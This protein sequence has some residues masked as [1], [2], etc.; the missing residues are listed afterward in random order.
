[1]SPTLPGPVSSDVLSV[2]C[3]LA[4]SRTEV[5]SRIQ[6]ACG[7]AH[8]GLRPMMAV[9]T[10]AKVTQLDALI[11]VNDYITWPGFGLRYNH[12]PL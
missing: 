1:M 9:I 10:A 11:V 4:A 7:R 6:S 2:V 8:L 5:P 12:C 3:G